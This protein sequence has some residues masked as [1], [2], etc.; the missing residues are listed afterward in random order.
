M[1]PGME[2]DVRTVDKL[3]N[4]KNQMFDD[5]NMWLAPFKFTRSSAAANC[6]ERTQELRHPNYVMLMFKAPKCISAIKLWNY[7]KTAERGVS[8]F[9]ILADDKQIFRGFASKAPSKQ[10]W[11]NSFRKDFS[12]AIIFSSEPKILNRFKDNINFQ[13]SKTQDIAMINERKVANKPG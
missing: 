9:E 2:K 6:N 12:T 3:F 5:A 10:V 7:S 4:G 13:A 11:Q 8:E 1:L